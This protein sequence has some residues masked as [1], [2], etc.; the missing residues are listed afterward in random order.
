[1]IA[2]LKCLLQEWSSIK[3][4]SSTKE[5]QLDN[6]YNSVNIFGIVRRI[7]P[8]LFSKYQHFGPMCK[9]YII[10]WV[11]EKEYQ[12]FCFFQVLYN[13]CF[14]IT[15]SAV[16]SCKRSYNC[17][18][19]IHEYLL[20]DYYTTNWYHADAHQYEKVKLKCEL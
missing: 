15:G 19:C 6:D 20:L 5:L 11:Y 8:T 13:T 2:S 3:T 18:T 16:Q 9:S 10:Q 12:L 4:I 14:Y 1:M 7:N 17:F